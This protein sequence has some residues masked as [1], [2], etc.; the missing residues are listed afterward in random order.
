[1]PLK[2][3]EMLAMWPGVKRRRGVLRWLPAGV[4]WLVAGAAAGAESSPFAVEVVEYV[5]GSTALPAYPD[6]LTALG[7]PERYTGEGI[8]PAAV[9]VFNP[10]WGADELVSIGEGGRLTVRFDRP[11]TNGA[12]H[13]YGVDLLI[14][15]N[16]FF[17]DIDFP[18]GVAGGIYQDGPMRVSVSA[19]GAHWESLAGE[20]FDARF[21]TQGYLDTAAQDP[22]PG[23][24]PT[25]FLRPVDPGLT[26]ADFAGLGYG[27]ILELYDGSGGGTPVDVAG[28]SVDQI[29]YVRIDVPEVDGVDAKVEV[30]AFAVV[31]E[32]ASVACLAVVAYCVALRRR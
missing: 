31:P 30:D 21:P 2:E 18:N 1:M 22:N 8:Y 4:G 11:I 17:E 32:P 14:F 13:L 27:E 25:D 12:G 24:Q 9:T 10:A 23:I 19:D 5:P 29:R 3:A 15:G 6:P 7:A 28:V 16:G 26:P 20:Y